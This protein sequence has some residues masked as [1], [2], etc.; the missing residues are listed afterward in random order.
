VSKPELGIRA[1]RPNDV[2]VIGQIIDAAFEGKPYA[3]GD[4]AELVEALRSQNALSV[5]LVAE[6][7]GVVVG[8][9]VISPARA[10]ASSAG[11][12]ALRPVAV[13]PAEQGN[14]VGAALIRAGLQV[15][16]DRGASGCISTGDLNYYSRPGRG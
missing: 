4:E 9:I 7:E 12:Y 11:W 1:G 5:S 13:L 3:A 10:S 8:Q 14:G 2:D 16:S 15:S 6:R